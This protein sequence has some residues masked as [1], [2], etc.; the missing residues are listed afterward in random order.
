[1][2]DGGFIVCVKI[3]LRLSFVFVPGQSSVDFGTYFN[4][5]RLMGP[6]DP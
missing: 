5:Y 4:N 3:D 2:K 6:Q 1:L